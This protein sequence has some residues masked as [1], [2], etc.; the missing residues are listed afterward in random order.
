MISV[1]SKV[2]YGNAVS[3]INQLTSNEG[4]RTRSS[5]LILL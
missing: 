1:L 5:G 2:S 4:Q 3:T